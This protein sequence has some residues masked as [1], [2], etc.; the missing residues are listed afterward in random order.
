[1]QEPSGEPIKIGFYAPITGPAA[2]DGESAQRAADLAVEVINEEGGVL[3]R[4]IELVSYDDAFSPDEA[5]NVVRRMIEQDNVDAIVSG[6]YSFTTRAGAPIAQE[7]GVPFMAA[8]AVHPSVTETG[9]YVWR[10]GALAP[11]QGLAGAQ[12]V[13]D[14]LQAQNVAILV[15]DNDFGISLTEGF[16]AHAA[17]LGMNIVYEEKYPLGESDFRPL[18]NG[19]RDANP[20]VI[21]ATGYYAEAAALVAQ[22]KEAGIDIQ[23][24]GQEGYDSPTFLE[25]AGENANGVIFTTD[26][27]R[28]SERPAVQEFL[29]RFEETYNHP[30]DAVGASVYDAV[31]VI[32]AGIEAGGS[33]EPQAILDGLKSLKDFDLAVTG[34]IFEFTPGRE[35]VRPI[36]AQLVRDNEFHFYAEIDDLS[37]VTPGK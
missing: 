18:L 12:I 26:L 15:V 32:A 6:S 24:V 37:L 17:E 2:A 8:Y 21:Y 33:T 36:G 30:A 16:K 3:G 7:A 34:P 22:M 23:I 28:D 14:N 11:I 10:I 5:A 9:E 35:V 4:P 1:V 20:D 25:L 13:H 31:R 27:N 19:I 29:R